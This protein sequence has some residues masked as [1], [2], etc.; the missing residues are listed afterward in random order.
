MR[1]RLPFL[2]RRSE[3]P[4]IEVRPPTLGAVLSFYHA[5][6]AYEGED[7]ADALAEMDGDAARRVLDTVAVNKPTSFTNEAGLVA[8]AQAYATVFVFRLSQEQEAAVWDVDVV[9]QSC[10]VVFAGSDTPEPASLER[11]LGKMPKGDAAALLAAPYGDALRLMGWGAV[12]H[13]ID[14]QL[15]GD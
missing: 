9:R 10:H 1:L 3:A 4:A 7:L 2:G 15:R 14:R 8:A 12:Q 6:G 11:A 13:E 5:L